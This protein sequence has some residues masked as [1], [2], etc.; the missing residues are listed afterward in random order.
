[1]KETVVT[2]THVDQLGEALPTIFNAGLRVKALVELASGVMPDGLLLQDP[3]S[4]LSYG[5]Q[6]ATDDTY[7]VLV[8][9]PVSKTWATITY[10]EQDKKEWLLVDGNEA[11][12]AKVAKTRQLDP[13]QTAN[14]AVEAVIKL[15]KR[16]LSSGENTPLPLRRIECSE[17]G[18]YEDVLDVFRGKKSLLLGKTQLEGGGKIKHPVRIVD[19]YPEDDTQSEFYALRMEEVGNETYL[20][21]QV[22]LPLWNHKIGDHIRLMRIV[23]NLDVYIAEQF[24]ERGISEVKRLRAEDLLEGYLL[25]A[26]IVLLERVQRAM[27]GNYDR[28]P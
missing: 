23:R 13:S 6:P 24:Q 4:Q 20:L 27:G 1:M 2:L 28:L 9:D 25:N 3:E 14:A 5:I 22:N 15:W 18:V 19:N 10:I 21:I 8:A 16:N 11:V 17:K 26:D 7:R 12:Q